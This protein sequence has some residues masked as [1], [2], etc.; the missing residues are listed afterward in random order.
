MLFIACCLDRIYCMSFSDK[1]NL[2]F[3]LKWFRHWWLLG[4]G[5]VCLIWYLSL[6]TKPHGIDLGIEFSDKLGHF[7]AYAWLM[8]WFGNLYQSMNGRLVFAGIFILMGIGL[9]ILQGLGQVRQFEY[10]DML[11]NTA[12]VLI[13]LLT[14]LTPLAKLLCWIEALLNFSYGKK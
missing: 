12:G 13:G 5:W 9:E 6:S 8:L 7:I 3:D 4:W 11:A 14:L 1:F 10:F 2:K